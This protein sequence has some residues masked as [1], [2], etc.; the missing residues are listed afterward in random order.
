M[1]GSKTMKSILLVVIALIGSSLVPLQALAQLK[2][3]LA[4]PMTGPAAAFGTQLRNGAEQAIAD[5]NAKGGVLGQPISI[6]LGDDASD[7]RQGASVA[8]RMASDNIKLVVGHFNSGVTLP[9]SS[10][11]AENGILMLTPAATNPQITE[12]GL[13]NVFRA[14]GRDDQQGVVAA[15]YITKN[16]S[17]KRIAIVHDKTT[18]GM[19]VANEVRKALADRNIRPIL[20]EGVNVGEK[21]FSTLISFMNS[22]KIDF[23]YW[24]GLH[25]ELGLIIRQSNERSAKFMF[26]ASD[27]AVSDELASI[28]GPALEGLKMTFPPDPRGRPEASEVVKRFEARG[29][30]PE[31]YTL[32]A[33]AS[34]EILRQA[35]D[36]AKST[37]PRKLAETMK[38]GKTFSTVLGSISYDPKGDRTSLDY[39]I[40]TWKKAAS[41]TISYFQD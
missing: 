1:E 21:D 17:K 23:V 25:T 5:I 6:V 8:N 2:I 18:Y 10:I 32:Y 29:I 3:G 41:G 28:A 15:E 7:P 4:G 34:F 19:G 40:Y 26:M 14:C 33:Y 38:S 24:G 37:D 30:N 12:R 9:A 22:Q 27:G 13:W 36:Q 16:H 35:I 31:A 20:Y 39:T 11:Y